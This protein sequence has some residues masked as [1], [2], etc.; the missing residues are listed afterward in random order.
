MRNFIKTLGAFAMAIGVTSIPVLASYVP[1][2]VRDGTP[3]S[4]T[5]GSSQKAIYSTQNSNIPPKRGESFYIN[6]AVTSSNGSGV[7]VKLYDNLGN[8]YGGKT[9][10]YQISVPDFEYTFANDFGSDEYAVVKINSTSSYIVSYK[11]YICFARG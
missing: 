1:S 8:L 11:C 4:G 7:V 5:V 2:A 3:Y 10:P 9:F 6:T